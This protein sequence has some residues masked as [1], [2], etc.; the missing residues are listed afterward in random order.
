VAGLNSVNPWGYQRG[1]LREREL[2][3]AERELSAAE[4]GALRVAVL[5]HQLVG[6]PWRWRKLPLAARTRVLGRLAAGGVELVL[7]GHI[8]QATVVTRSDFQVLDGS[9]ECVLVTAPGLGRPRP[10]RGYEVRG[11]MVLRVDEEEFTLETHAWTGEAFEVSAART[12]PR[13]P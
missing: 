11:V 4:H 5:H 3:R 12:F 10:G 2:E 1:R 7:G 6:A 8:H 13:R 9:P